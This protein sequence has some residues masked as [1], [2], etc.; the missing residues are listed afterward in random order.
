MGRIWDL[1]KFAGNTAL[2]DEYSRKV[3]YGELDE[4]AHMISRRTRSGKVL[5]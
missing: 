2:I 5:Q 3:S 1:Q 4:K